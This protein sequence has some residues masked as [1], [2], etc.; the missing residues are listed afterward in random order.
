MLSPQ[1]ICTAFRQSKS[2]QGKPSTTTGL[3]VTSPCMVFFL[4][5]ASP[6]H[7]FQ[8]C[9]NIDRF[10]K[11]FH[12]NFQ[13]QQLIFGTHLGVLTAFFPLY[14][15]R[16]TVGILSSLKLHLSLSCWEILRIQVLLPLFQSGKI[17][18]KKTD[19]W[20]ISSMLQVKNYVFVFQNLQTCTIL[21]VT[22][23]SSDKGYY[24]SML[25]TA[26]CQSTVLIH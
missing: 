17:N 12:C 15:L 22:A 23:L 9:R 11:N 13:T 24:H 14:I 2:H 21:V 6:I 10:F 25:E 8:L 5:S 20:S 26:L 18:S 1:S 7:V 16:Y 19:F 3:L 4:G